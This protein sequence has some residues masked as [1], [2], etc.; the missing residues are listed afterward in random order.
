M[1]IVMK[2]KICKANI[3]DLLSLMDLYK[4]LATDGVSMLN[5]KEARKIF[6]KLKTYPDYKIYKVLANKK[7]IGTFCL[8]IVDKIRHTGAPFGIVEDVIVHPNYRRK[9]VGRRNDGICYGL[10]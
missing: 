1:V 2:F 4:H 8:I 3:S 9:G 10:L 7:V 5:L 6:N